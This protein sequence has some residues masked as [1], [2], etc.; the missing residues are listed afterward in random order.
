MLKE[1]I[2]RSK[3]LTIRLVDLFLKRDYSIIDIAASGSSYNGAYSARM[4]MKKYLDI[5]V[6]VTTPFSF[7]HYE[8]RKRKDIFPIVVSQSGS[9]LNSIQALQKLKDNGMPAISLTGNPESDIKDY[10]DVTIEYGVGIEK[11]VYVTK[12]VVTLME[13]LML[14][15]LEAALR[16]NKITAGTYGNAMEQL[17]KAADLSHTMYGNS[18]SFYRQNYKGLSSFHQAYLCGCGANYGTALEGALKIGE[19]IKV[20]AGA[21]EPEEYL[22]GPNIQLTPSYTVFFIAS[23]TRTSGRISEIYRATREITDNAYIITNDAS[24]RGKQVILVPEGLDED[25]SPLY[26][27]VLFQYLSCHMTTELV[28]WKEHPLFHK[29]EARIHS[30]TASYEKRRK[31]EKR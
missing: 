14:F 13:F 31:K 4:Y 21:Y 28:R 19:T 20:P 15:S 10:S 8:F 1:N 9:S 5:E 26:N 23:G 11:D 27:V 18:Q 30:K 25:A 6:R 2:E 17:K 3:E 12:G 22:H 7:E 24:L 29:M 16:K